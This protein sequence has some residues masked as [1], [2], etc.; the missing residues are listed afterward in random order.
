VSKIAF[1]ALYSITNFFDRISQNTIKL[2]S[3]HHS[4]A[5]TIET[6][7]QQLY[8]TIK[9]LSTTKRKVKAKYEKLSVIPRV[10]V[11]RSEDS[12]TAK[13]KQS[14]ITVICTLHLKY[15][16]NANFHNFVNDSYPQFV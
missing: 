14:R 8:Q 12:G 7:N 1:H 5:I 4:D 6:L 10:L 9:Q 2:F 15:D 3:F 16:L 11:L 13:R